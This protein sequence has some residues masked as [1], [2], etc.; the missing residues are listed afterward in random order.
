LAETIARCASVAAYLDAGLV[1]EAAFV[2]EREAQGLARAEN[3]LAVAQYIA[4][5]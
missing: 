1:T 5:H 2:A 4:K 3:S